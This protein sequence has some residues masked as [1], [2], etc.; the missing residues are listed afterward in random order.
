MKTNYDI[1]D[2]EQVRQHLEIRMCDP[3]E[4][5]GFQ[6]EV[7]TGG[8]LDVSYRIVME[9]NGKWTYSLVI[10]DQML[11]A[12][13]ITKEQLHKDAITAE[14]AKYE[15][16][17]YRME[18]ALIMMTFGNEA[19]NL[20]EGDP[21]SADEKC[22][23][24][25]LTNQNNRHGANVM[26]WDGV[27]EKAGEVLGADYYILP[28]SAHELILVVDREQLDCE[29]LQFIVKEVN[30]TEVEQKD[31]LSNKVFFYDRENGL[32]RVVSNG[33]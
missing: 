20:L 7:R 31:F 1:L 6:G 21:K 12:W 19:E 5:P 30:E 26:A 13:N 22:G 24:Y 23:M 15:P 16:C 25:I 27:L 17:L 14:M 29:E 28:S 8:S 10:T 33:K 18:D 11:N 2:Y 32:V 9:E 3:D 4:R